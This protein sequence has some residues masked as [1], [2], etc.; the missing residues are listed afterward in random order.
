MAR[1]SD[2]L[3][4]S[5]TAALFIALSMIAPSQSAARAETVATA[6]SP[7]IMRGYVDARFGQLHYAMSTPALPPSQRRQ[8][9]VLLH[10]TANSL[11]EFGPLIGAMGQD[12]V[13]IAFDTPGYGGS[14]APLSQPRIEDYA[15]AIA[16]GLKALGYSDRK[17]VDVMGNHTGAFVATALA[18]QHP[19]MVR[20]MA[21][22]GVFVVPD[23]ELAMYRDRLK[24]P[25]SSAEVF[26]T[27]CDW[28][29]RLEANYTK[30]GAPD[31]DWGYMRADSLLS[32]RLIRSREYGHT[33]AYE[34]AGRVRPE[35][36]K[37]RQPVLL[38]AVTDKIGE[39]TK[40]SAPFFQNATLLD[41]PHIT[42]GTGV[43]GL[44]LS[45]T[46]DVAAVLRNY[47]D[48]DGV[49]NGKPN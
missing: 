28:L 33:A 7:R 10:Q 31:D 9:L 37:I 8:P 40:Q 26:H 32:G 27:F 20:R 17:P 13:T 19:K 2:A 11:A 4:A 39:A 22:V 18:N 29:P 45:Q 48:R 14:D 49:G 44:F 34:Y 6:P 21:L 41:L 47:L 5:L 30:I 3:S 15:E 25:A 38:M 36:R 12:R 16:D 35:L 42:A 24:H 23:E 1:A 46:A 43:D